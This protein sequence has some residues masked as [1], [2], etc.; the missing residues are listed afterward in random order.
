MQETRLRADG[1]KSVDVYLSSILN[2]H[3]DENGEKKGHI[4]LLGTCNH[5]NTIREMKNNVLLRT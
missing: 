3:K 2:D 4:H 5:Q 1:K